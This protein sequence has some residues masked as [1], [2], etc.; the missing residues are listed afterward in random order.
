RTGHAVRLGGSQHLLH[1]GIQG[2]P[3]LPGELLDRAAPAALLGRDS[4]RLMLCLAPLLPL[5]GHG[6]LRLRLPARCLL[7]PVAL[8]NPGTD[9]LR[10]APVIASMPDLS[11][12]AD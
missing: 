6:L 7:Q 9:L 11:G 8:F 4:P 10:C 5:D 3:L 2:V 1:L 12:V